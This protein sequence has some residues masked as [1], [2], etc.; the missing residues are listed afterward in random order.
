MNAALKKLTVVVTLAGLVATGSLAAATPAA[1]GWGWRHG[2]G[3]G[4]HRE[5]WGVPVVAG[6]LGAVA[7]GT[8]AN[9][10]TAPTYYAAGPCYFGDRPV[11]DAWGNVVD[12]RRARICE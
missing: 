7:V 1:A 12:Y 6:L 9:A 11:V 8:L 2:G 3:W 5:G 10:A 4:Y